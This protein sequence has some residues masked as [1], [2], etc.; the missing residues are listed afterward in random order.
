[1]KKNWQFFLYFDNRFVLISVIIV[2]NTI[3]LYEI[4]D[5]FHLLP[6]KLSRDYERIDDFFCNLAMKLSKGT[7]PYPSDNSKRQIDDILMTRPPT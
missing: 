4:V 6:R 5:F 1:M 2:D 7:C 3:L